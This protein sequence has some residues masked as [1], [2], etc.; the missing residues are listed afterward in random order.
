MTVAASGD[1]GKPRPAVIVQSDA[2]PSEHASVIVCQMTS[3]IADA[4]DFRITI[5]PGPENGLRIRS[6]I[7]ADKPVTVRRER[8]G[9]RIGQL[10]PAD[11]ARLNV[12]IAFMMGLA[13]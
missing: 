5:E 13:D 6:Q 9:R 8:I 4:P 7:M 1:Y 12:A 3:D 10:S 2:F 11:V